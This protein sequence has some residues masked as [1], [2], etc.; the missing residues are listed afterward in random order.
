MSRQF[1]VDG[2][3]VIKKTPGLSE[4]R[5]EDGRAGLIRFIRERRPQGSGRNSITV[6]FDGQ[7]FAGGDA[8]LPAGDVHVVFTRGSSAD[9]H[10]REAV[11]QSR[12]PRHLICVTDDRELALACR[13]RGAVTWSVDEFLSRGYR[14]ETKAARRSSEA[15]RR[16]GD[17][18]TIPSMVAQRIDRELEA[19]WVRKKP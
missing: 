5:L 9:D 2:Y 1:L 12:D 19:L 11:E 17:G 16:G 4:R 15:E 3:N 6:V 13:H 7:E 8:V 18:K 14:E 10:I